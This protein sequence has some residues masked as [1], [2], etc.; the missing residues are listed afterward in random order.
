MSKNININVWE[1]S[2]Y[3]G[4]NDYDG[5]RDDNLS[6]CVAMDTRFT[7]EEIVEIFL[8]R[9][10]KKHRTVVIKASLLND[11]QD[12][13]GNTLSRGMFDMLLGEVVTTHKDKC[14]KSGLSPEK[15]LTAAVMS[16]L[17]DNH[18]IYDLLQLTDTSEISRYF[19]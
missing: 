14:E 12:N 8:N 19:A 5:E 9:Y 10:N 18:T 7:K 6:F 17:T 11:R 1:I 3:K 2:G 15:Y 16:Y 4:E 13:T